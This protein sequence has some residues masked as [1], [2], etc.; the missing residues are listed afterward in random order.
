M[1]VGLRPNSLL[2]R[3]SEAKLTAGPAMSSTKAVPGESPL[4][5]SERA[6]GMEPVAQTY[7]GMAMTK[8]KSMERAGR[9]ANMA[10]KSAGT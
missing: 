3:V 1:I 10:K 9:S 6:M 5:M 8:T 7:M 4:S 2:M